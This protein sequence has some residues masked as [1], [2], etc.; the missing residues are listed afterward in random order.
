MAGRDSTKGVKNSGNSK[1]RRRG[2]AVVSGSVGA[3]AAAAA[4]ATGS[5]APAK[6]DII[7][8]LLDPIIQPVITSLTDAIAGFDPAA[9]T[10]LTSWTD[11]LLSSL[12]SIDLALPSTALPSTADP[13]ASAASAAP[14]G[15]DPT[16]YDIPITVQEGTE[17]TVLVSVD[18]ST[19][20]PTLVDTGSSGLVIPSTDLSLTQWLDLGFP[21]GI[22]ESGYSGGIDYIYL[23]YDD[24]TVDYGN[25]ALDTTNTPIDVEILSWP[26]SFSSGSPLDFQQFLADNDSPGGI[27][28]IGDNTSGPTTSPFADYGGVAVNVP[29]GELVVGGNPGTTVESTPGAPIS[30]D[31]ISIDGGPLQ[32]VSVDADS[33]GV[34]GTI[35]ESLLT[36]S[37][38]NSTTD[39]VNPG[40]TIAVYGNSS[41]TD[42][43]Y[44]YT[45]T[46]ANDPYAVSGSTMDTGIEPF[47]D[48]T[49][50]L[51]YSPTGTGTTDYDFAAF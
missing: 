47:E 48:G 22:S 32:Q 31:Y 4:M 18:G 16:T 19:A 3:F 13:V 29:G 14:A 50:Y 51:D 23:T 49:V 38:Y 5:A 37:E 25:G 1:V 21:T 15:S 9:A 46:A 17:P 28:G 11:S 36:S 39:L 12:N 40:T 41:G 43:L 20:E 7:D 44:A 42:E 8:T 34:T 24:A 26:T 45:V 33:G 6:A 10:D 2:L 30:T 27:L 35:P